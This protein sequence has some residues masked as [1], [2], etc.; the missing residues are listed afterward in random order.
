MQGVYAKMVSRWVNH[1]GYQ[2]CQQALQLLCVAKHGLKIDDLVSIISSASN[3]SI[4][5]ISQQ[6]AFFMVFA[7]GG[8]F[9]CE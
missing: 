8:A 6:C 4:E 2:W 1:L 9:S 7:R 5:V 3:L